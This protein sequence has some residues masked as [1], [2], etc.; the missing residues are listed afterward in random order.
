MKR[1]P[2]WILG[3]FYSLGKGNKI[4]RGKI[5]KSLNKMRRLLSEHHENEEYR[6]L[7]KINTFD[8]FCKA[9]NI[10]V[11]FKPT[12]KLIDKWILS[13]YDDPNYELIGKKKPHRKNDKKS[14]TL[15][16]GDNFDR[17]LIGGQKLQRKVCGVKHGSMV[18]LI[19]CW[20]NGE[21][22][23]KLGMTSQSLSYRFRDFPYEWA[24]ITTTKVN[25]NWTYEYEQ[26]IHGLMKNHS[27]TPLI[28]FGGYTECYRLEAEKEI[29]SLL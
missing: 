2:A 14:S 5:N 4:H 25:P 3:F 12:K 24:E 28:K 11:E 7:N 23:L 6:R 17:S 26:A 20:R 16:K 27:Y 21:K 10:E 22:F 9:F 18:Y 8:E 15:F 1:L 13:K 19:M 29:L